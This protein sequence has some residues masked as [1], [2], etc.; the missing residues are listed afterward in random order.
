MMSLSPV[1]LINKL[2]LLNSFP[3]CSNHVPSV[4]LVDVKTYNAVIN[5]VATQHLS[6]D[7]KWNYVLVCHVVF[8]CQL[9]C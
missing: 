1:C 2:E 9:I 6:V 7:E 3:F 4:V 8:V 5:S